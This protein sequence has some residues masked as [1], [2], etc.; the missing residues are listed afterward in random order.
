MKNNGLTF[1]GFAVIAAA[2][3][4]MTLSFTGCGDVREDMGRSSAEA[5]IGQCIDEACESDKNEMLKSN[6]ET[7]F[8]AVAQACYENDIADGDYTFY[9]SAESDELLAQKV[10]EIFDNTITGYAHITVTDGLPD[11]AEWSKT[12]DGESISYPAAES[13]ED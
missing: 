10:N 7:L 13:T 11:I 3:S 6:S 12:E 4:V 1:K 2:L 9:L 8:N 5:N